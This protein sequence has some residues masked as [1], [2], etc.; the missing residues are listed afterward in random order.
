MHFKLVCWINLLKAFRADEDEVLRRLDATRLDLERHTLS[1]SAVDTTEAWTHR[2]S[3]AARKRQQLKIAD[4]PHLK[5]PVRT[6]SCNSYDDLE[7][8]LLKRAAEV[9]SFAPTEWRTVHD[10]VATMKEIKWRNFFDQEHCLDSTCAQYY[11]RETRAQRYSDDDLLTE[12]TWE[13]DVSDVDNIPDSPDY[14]P[15]SPPTSYDEDVQLPR[16]LDMYCTAASMLPQ[17][18]E[19]H[20]EDD[21]VP[22]EASGR[23]DDAASSAES[24]ADEDRPETPE[25]SRDHPE[26]RC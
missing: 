21:A 15:S 13:E 10:G 5:V 22:S 6:R 8:C 23:E 19:V 11:R 25:Q 9:F 26:A 3:F 20:Y 17:P 18:E 16:K 14:R 4:A 7:E 24:G 1:S 12:E 2:I